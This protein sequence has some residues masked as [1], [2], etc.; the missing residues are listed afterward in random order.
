MDTNRSKY[1]RNANVC[2]TKVTQLKFYAFRLQCRE[3]TNACLLRGGQL[4]L[5]QYI[6]D[7]YSSIEESRLK[8]ICHNQPSL[9][10]E[11]YQ[12]LADMVTL[13]NGSTSLNGGTAGRRIVLPSSFTGGPRFMHQLYHDSMA[14]VR[15]KGKP[16]LFITFTCN[17]NWDDIRKALLSGQIAQD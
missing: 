14:I 9:R 11:V 10:S 12:G 4:L 5:Q 16:D 7:A 17:P 2:R 3:D 8:W 6:V 13:S 15:K 1:R